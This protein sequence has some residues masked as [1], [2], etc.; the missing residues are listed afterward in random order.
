MRHT[1]QQKRA[2]DRLNHLNQS[3][4]NVISSK[5][6]MGFTTADVAEEAQCSIG[7]VYRY[8]NNAADI[9]NALVP[10]FTKEMTEEFMF[11]VED[12][13]AEENADKADEPLLSTGLK[14]APEMVEA[15]PGFY[16]SHASIQRA[17]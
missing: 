14:D 15:D 6:I 8:Y 1:P 13:G 9:V 3:A 16:P 11:Q 12:R 5:G 4:I 7:T 10:N 2:T 17:S